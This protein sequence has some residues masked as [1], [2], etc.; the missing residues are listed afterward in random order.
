MWPIW[1]A[2]NIF[3]SSFAR[4]VRDLESP[5]ELRHTADLGEV[6]TYVA[7]GPPMTGRAVPRSW[8]SVLC[9]LLHAA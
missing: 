7:G 6:G 3:F 9:T 4:F 2:S 1:H 5:I 8:R